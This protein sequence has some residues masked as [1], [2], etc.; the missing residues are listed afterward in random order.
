MLWNAINDPL[1]GYFQDNS[2]WPVFRQRKMSIYYG[3]PVWA[4]TFMLPWFNWSKFF[5]QFSLNM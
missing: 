3:A 1:F 2:D 4:F 5:G